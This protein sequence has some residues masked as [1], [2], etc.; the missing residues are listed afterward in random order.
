MRKFFNLIHKYEISL[1]AASTSYYFIVASFSLITLFLQFYNSFFNYDNNIVLIKLLNNLGNNKLISLFSVNYFS[2]FIFLSLIWSSSRVLNGFNRAS[3]IIY[4]IN[5]R[6]NYIKERINSFFMFMVFVGIIIF[7]ISTLLYATQLITKIFKSYIVYS[8]VHLFI[9]LIVIFSIVVILYIYI[10][11]MKIKFK[12]AYYGALISTCFIYVINVI[13]YSFVLIAD[14][15]LTNFGIINIISVLFLWIYSIN[16][17]L[18]IGLYINYH[19]RIIDNG[20]N[21]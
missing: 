13:F 1:L 6:R 3:D 8:L 17:I 18:I 5:V 14:N 10:P 19:I 2:P 12:N 9:E 4:N 15:I 21:I 11:P 16:F 7:E 20:Q